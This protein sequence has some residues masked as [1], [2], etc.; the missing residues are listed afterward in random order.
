MNDVEKRKFLPLPGLELQPLGLY[1][2]C[3]I[4][5]LV[6]YIKQNNLQQKVKA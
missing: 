5:A 6:V 3:A 2:D 1:T 4:P